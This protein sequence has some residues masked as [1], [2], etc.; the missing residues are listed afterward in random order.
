[1]N[2]GAMT[3]KRVVL[4]LIAALILSVPA[5]AQTFLTSTTNS[6]AMNA[7]QNTIVVAS[8]TGIA[9]GGALYVNYEWMSVRSVSGTT[10]TVQRGV[11]GTV[12][13]AHGVTQTVV[14]VPV[15]AVPL[16][17][18]STDPAGTAGMG[19][20]TAANHQFLP[21][22]NTSNG[23]IWSCVSGTW[24]GTNSAPLTYNSLVI[25]PT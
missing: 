11:A 12:A 1:M 13:N 17:A 3:M 24:R 16:V 19:T 20:C 21:Y 22:I 14:I 8:A 10:I 4:G 7:S 2:K 25:N 15:A 6:A 18:V 23:N 5:S 9:A